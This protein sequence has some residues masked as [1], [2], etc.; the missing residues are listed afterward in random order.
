MPPL[1]GCASEKARDL[2]CCSP[3]AVEARRVAVA[4]RPGVVVAGVVA[5][6]SVVFV[7]VDVIGVTVVV[8][9]NNQVLCTLNVYIGSHANYL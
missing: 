6:M 9:A 1:S 8:P 3:V 2:L 4:P 5:V 7:V